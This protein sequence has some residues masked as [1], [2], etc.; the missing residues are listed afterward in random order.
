MSKKDNASAISAKDQN[1]IKEKHDPSL[2]IF[3]RMIEVQKLVQTVDKNSTVKMSENDKGYKATTHDDVAAALHLPLAQCGVFM[4]PDIEKYSVSSFEKANQ[5]GKVV[6]WYRTDMDIIVKWI[7]VDKPEDVITSKGA[8]F[9]LDTSD[10]SFA[11]AYSLALKIVLLKVH[12]LESRDGEE[13]RPFDEANGG[14]KFGKG[15]NRQNN[16]QNQKPKNDAP[17]KP[18]EALAPKDVIYPF[19]SSIKGK[20]IGDVETAT[21][22]KASGWLKE[23]MA[24]EPKPKKMS[25]IAFIYSQVKA[26]LIDRNPPAPDP[27]DD[28]PE[29][30]DPKTGE[31]ADPFP[32]DDVQFT[33]E[34]GSQE[35]QTKKN[36]PDPADYVIPQIKGLELSD[37]VG[38]PLKKIS[39]GELRAAIKMIDSHMKTVP[40]PTNIGEIFT[41]RT[42]ITSFLNSVGVSL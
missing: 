41:V 29:N 17:P 39:E 22:E 9:A 6:T 7:N 11:K 5:W 40:P 35:R 32:P 15:E 3:Q 18:K 13:N 16:S 27:K 8:A 25:Q 42:S 34:E 2:N 14:E 12:L 37:L 28:I 23:Q 24:L 30:V 38:K 1:A 20:K 19:E 26:V 10:K 4:L 31:V 33:P 36:Q 21:L